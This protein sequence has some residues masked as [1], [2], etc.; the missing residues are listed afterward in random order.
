MMGGRVACLLAA[1][2]VG[3]LGEPAGQQQDDRYRAT[4]NLVSVYATVTDE[5]GRLVTD[6]RKD[7][8]VVK[9]N[10]RKQS[11]AVFNNNPEP[12]SVI[13]LLDCSGSMSDEIETV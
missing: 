8:F 6:L 12:I 4:L 3:T 1:L 5:A 7:E 13:V 2:L 11:L 9:D 10:G